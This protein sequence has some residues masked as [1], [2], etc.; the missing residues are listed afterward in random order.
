MVNRNKWEEYARQGGILTS[1]TV[2]ES[3][4]DIDIHAQEVNLC[5][6]DEYAL[7][8]G[9]VDKSDLLI[10]K[11]TPSFDD[12]LVLNNGKKVILSIHESS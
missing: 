4:E 10:D 5:D 9:L 12:N 6:T 2:T 8:K 1:L 3:M 7:M 11:I